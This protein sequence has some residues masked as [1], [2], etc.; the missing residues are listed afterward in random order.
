M[1]DEINEILARAIC[2]ATTAMHPDSRPITSMT[3]SMGTNIVGPPAPPKLTLGSPEW[4]RHTASAEAVV[5]ALRKAG[6]VIRS[7]HG[8][9]RFGRAA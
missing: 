3:I 2:K 6:Y 8:G 5:D 9:A 4:V 7:S 1:S